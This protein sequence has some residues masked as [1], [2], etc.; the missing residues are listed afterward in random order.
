MLDLD[1]GRGFHATGRSF[2]QDGQ[3]PQAVPSILLDIINR[4]TVLSTV[5]LFKSMTVPTTATST[6]LSSDETADETADEV[7]D[8]MVDEM[9]DEMVDETVDTTL[10]EATVL[11]NVALWTSLTVPSTAALIL[12][13]Q[14]S[15]CVGHPRP[16]VD[17]PRAMDV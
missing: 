13:V 15:Q 9:A 12:P 11:S 16:P 10:H 5:A 14:G 1:H 17:S 8:E 3:R 7:V 6:A 4:V 2:L